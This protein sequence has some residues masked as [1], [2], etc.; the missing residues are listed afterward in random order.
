[1]SRYFNFIIFAAAIGAA[2]VLAFMIGGL[3]YGAEEPPRADRLAKQLSKERKQHKREVARYRKTVRRQSEFGIDHA[4]R[5]ASH[6]YGVS[7]STLHRCVRGESQYNRFARNPIRVGRGEHATGY[8]QFLPSTFR[9]QTTFGRA[10][11]SIYGT[12]AQ[13]LGAAQII[14]KDGGTRQWVAC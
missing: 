12:Y 14:A 7:Q 10:G 13:A 9:R 2:L 8:F 3:A 11:W 6:L 1:M 4:I 5:L